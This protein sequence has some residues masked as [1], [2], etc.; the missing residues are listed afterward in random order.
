MRRMNGFWA[1]LLSL[2]GC[3]SVPE[4]IEPVE[5]FDLERYLGTWYEIARLDH[6]YERGL[7]KV[8]A[9]YSKRDDGLVKV[10]NRGYS[11]EDGEWKEIVGR[12]KPVESASR[13]HLQVSFFGPFYASYVIFELDEDYRYA[14]VT[15]RTKGALWLLSRTKT[16]DD[17]VLAKF[18]ERTRE[19]GFD[20]EKLI[21]VEH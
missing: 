14:F 13:G 17:S 3:T 9:Q 4:G 10:V 12:A 6:F 5:D 8:T 15:S 1:I 19:L 18:R 16:V 21:M 20:T 7:S 11:A 2:A